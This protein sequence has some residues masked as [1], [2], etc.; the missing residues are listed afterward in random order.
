MWNTSNLLNIIIKAIS[1]RLKCK[2]QVIATSLP[3][4]QGSTVLIAVNKCTVN[5]IKNA[6]RIDRDRNIHAFLFF[7]FDLLEVSVFFIRY[8]SRI[9]NNDF[10]ILYSVSRSIKVMII[11]M[12]IK[13]QSS[14]QTLPQQMIWVIRISIQYEVSISIYTH[15]LQS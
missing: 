2:P 3:F 6:F 4:R 13:N 11:R 7:Y 5:L 12:F 9:V 10:H 14:V 8:I 15:S 1:L